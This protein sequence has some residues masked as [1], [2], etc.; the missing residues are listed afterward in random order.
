MEADA[1][2]PASAPA[3]NPL[4]VPVLDDASHFIPL[5]VVGENAA[6]CRGIDPPCLTRKGPFA[7]RAS[8]SF[9][10]TRPAPMTF[11][12]TGR[13]HEVV[14]ERTGL[15]RSAS[16]FYRAPILFRYAHGV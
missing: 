6:A 12:L 2:E 1:I 4:C 13:A 16:R 5:R 10:G 11:C 14:G 8:V 7:L 3:Q 15:K 9:Y